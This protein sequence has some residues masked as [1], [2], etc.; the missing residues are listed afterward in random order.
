MEARG[1]YEALIARMRNW[2]ARRDRSTSEVERKLQELGMGEKDLAKAIQQLTSEQ[3][4]DDVRFTE[5]FVSGRVRIKKW[6]RIKIKHALKPHQ[7]SDSLISAAFQS[8]IKEDEYEENLR[9]VLHSKGWRPGKD[10][11][12][13]QRQ[14]LLRYAYQ[15]GYESS[16]INAVLDD[17]GFA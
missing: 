16:L 13:E 9:S 10:L 14:K 5:S 11:S 3:Y 2:C 6:G 4:L 15:R 12:Y 17:R 7:I 1:E 8:V